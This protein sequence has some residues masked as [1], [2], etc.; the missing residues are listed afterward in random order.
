MLRKI[1]F[2]SAL[3]AL[4]HYKGLKKEEYLDHFN[5]VIIKRNTSEIINLK[6][7]YI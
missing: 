7:S 1:E 2:D 5:I 3:S 6:R 4:S